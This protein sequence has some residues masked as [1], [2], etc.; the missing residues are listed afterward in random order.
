[1]NCNNDAVFEGISESDIYLVCVHCVDISFTN[2]HRLAWHI[3]VRMLCRKS[4]AIIIWRHQPKRRPFCGLWCKSIHRVSKWRTKCI[5]T[6]IK[7]RWLLHGKCHAGNTLCWPKLLQPGHNVM[8]F[9]FPE[10]TTTHLYFQQPWYPQLCHT[11]GR[12]YFRTPDC[13]AISLGRFSSITHLLIQFPTPTIMAS[14]R[15]SQ[16][17]R[18]HIL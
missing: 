6:C 11:S 7:K 9:R 13:K 4:P 3:F 15:L 12:K 17:S 10:S 16:Q 8:F 2:C 14:R 1:M 18:S 5:N